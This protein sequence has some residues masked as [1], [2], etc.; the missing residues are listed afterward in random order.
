[1]VIIMFLN[2]L[3]YKKLKKIAY[4]FNLI[5]LKIKE[6]FLLSKKGHSS[7]RFGPFGVLPFGFGLILRNVLK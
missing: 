1:M 4:G 6:L 7:M 5:K 3:V 2:L